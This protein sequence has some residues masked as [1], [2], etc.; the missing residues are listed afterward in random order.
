[1]EIGVASSVL[2]R[3]R[4]E[5][6]ASLVAELGYSFIDLWGGRPHLYPPDMGEEELQSVRRVLN[7]NDLRLNCVMPVFFGYPYDLF[8]ESKTA[9]ADSLQYVIA[10]GENAARLGADYLLVCPGR[11]LFGQD[12]RQTL[13]RFTEALD[14]ICHRCRE[15]G[16]SVLLEPVNRTTFDLINTAGQAMAIVRSIGADNIGI[17]LDTGHMNLES[18]TI[19]EAI[20]AADDRL[21]HVHLND[22]DGHSQTNQ[23]PGE[24]SFDFPR[25]FSALRSAGYSGGVTVE[26]GGQYRLEPRGAL[27][28]S[29]SE[30]KRFLEL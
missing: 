6:A 7:G 26:I 8:I 22:N 12:A 29:L 23:I 11:L 5:D 20:K 15:L 14:A 16:L 30:V 4:I 24:G 21:F 3:Y 9:L 10:N 17:V 18:E 27:K 28:R 25:F 19:E 2:S 1:M 13:D